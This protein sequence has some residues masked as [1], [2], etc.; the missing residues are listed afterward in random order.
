MFMVTTMN[1]DTVIIYLI[2]MFYFLGIQDTLSC[3]CWPW[4]CPPH[5]L[6]SRPKQR[7]FFELSQDGTAIAAT[8]ILK[9]VD[10]NKSSLLLKIIFQIAQ[11]L[12]LNKNGIH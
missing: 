3:F 8:G 4:F 6:Q 9:Q 1:R 7:K 12:Q 2:F 11:T 5:C 10:W